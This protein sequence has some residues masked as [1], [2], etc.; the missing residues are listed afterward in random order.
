M[1]ALV[2]ALKRRPYLIASSRSFLISCPNGLEL[3]LCQ[4]VVP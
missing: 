3:F 2:L 4:S 1:L